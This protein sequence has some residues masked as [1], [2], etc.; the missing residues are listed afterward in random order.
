MKKLKDYFKTN[1]V[2]CSWAAQQLGIPCQYFNDWLTGARQIPPKYW[3]KLIEI[4][5][6]EVT[7]E[8]FLNY[9]WERKANGFQQ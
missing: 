5:H 3:E 6:G 2:K 7:K 4:T 1:G 9:F 8:D